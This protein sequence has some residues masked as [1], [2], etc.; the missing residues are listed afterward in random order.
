MER[1]K[2][3][4]LSSPDSGDTATGSSATAHQGHHEVQ[5][6]GFPFAKTRDDQQHFHHDNGNRDD[7]DLVKAPRKP[8]RLE[9]LIAKLGLDA[10]TIIM[11]FKYASS[12]ATTST[13]TL[14]QVQ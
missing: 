3:E 11:M 10:G 8:N 9:K 1:E 4:D 13:S 5:Q 14:T 7:E 2:Y 12:T 6:N